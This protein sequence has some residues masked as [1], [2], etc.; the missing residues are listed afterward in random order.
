MRVII[1]ASHS[2]KQNGSVMDLTSVPG[3]KPF[4]M[5]IR[6]INTQENLHGF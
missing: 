4:R 3:Y 5:M 1:L 2:T 6:D